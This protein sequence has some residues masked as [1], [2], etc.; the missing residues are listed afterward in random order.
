MVHRK[1]LP[2]W[3]FFVCVYLG[4]WACWLPFVLAHQ[5]TPS[6]PLLLGLMMPSLLG[7]VLTYLTQGRKGSAFDTRSGQPWM[8]ARRSALRRSLWVTKSPCPAFG[9][10]IYTFPGTNCADRRPV[11]SMSAD[12]SAVP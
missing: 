6:A 10:S 9:Y 12:A 11:T 3:V 2:V 4:S 7:I 8:K 1:H 5:P